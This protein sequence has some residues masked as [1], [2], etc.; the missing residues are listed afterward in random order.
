MWSF[1]TQ[2]AG[3]LVNYF[4]FSIVYYLL[5]MT[6]FRPLHVFR[7]VSQKGRKT[8]GLLRRISLFD[9]RIPAGCRMESLFVLALVVR[10]IPVADCCPSLR[11]CNLYHVVP[12][13]CCG[14]HSLS[15]RFFLAPSS[16]LARAP[17]FF[18]LFLF[19]LL[20]QKEAPCGVKQGEIGFFYII[21]ICFQYEGRTAVSIFLH[22]Q[23]CRSL[24]VVP[25]MEGV[26]ILSESKAERRGSYRKKV[27][28]GC[29]GKGRSATVFRPFVT[30]GEKHISIISVDY[31]KVIAIKTPPELAQ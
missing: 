25:D 29:A 20:S 27:C 22:V 13:Y 3:V 1:S 14:S 28:N 6:Y 17:S 30:H 16:A 19:S 11:R 4:L 23:Q 10:G 26:Q 9:F 24:S 8:H 5:N 2:S 12:F 21:W 31:A 15:D 7:H 18:F